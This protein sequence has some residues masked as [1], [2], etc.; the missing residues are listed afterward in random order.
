MRML[1]STIVLIT[2]STGPAAAE[3][4]TLFGD[5]R[6][7]IGYN[8]D[9]EGNAAEETKASIVVAPGTRQA[10]EVAT[11]LGPT[12]AIRAVSRVRFGVVM[13]GETDSGIG[14]GA[15]V[16]AEDAED[17]SNDEGQTAGSVFVTGEAGTLTFGDTE[18]ADAQHV[19]DPVENLSL[20]GLGDFNETP[21]ISN[22]GGFGDDAI[23][24]AADPEALP[25]V[26][27]DYQVGGFGLSLST[28]RQ[29]RDMGVGASYTAE[30]D[31]G[32]ITGGPAT[33]TSQPLSPMSPT[34]RRRALRST[35]ASSGRSA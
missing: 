8:I 28:S 1:A 6:L 26:R 17:A 7:G 31:W 13:T 30:F 12:D 15:E 3:G 27:Y 14:F 4:V 32:S 25:T 20:T 19:G 24:F 22:G 18:G 16:Q 11:R 10:R 33:M 5:A 35:L 2:T 29:L 21:Y 34:A 23:Q 9:N